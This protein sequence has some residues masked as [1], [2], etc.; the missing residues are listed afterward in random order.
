MLVVQN[1]HHFLDSVEI[2]Q[3]IQNGLSTWKAQGSCL[4]IVGPPIVF[5]PELAKY[6]TTLEFQLPGLSD[7]LHIQEEL[8]ESVGV[9]DERT[10]DIPVVFRTALS[11]TVDETKG[12]KLGAI[13]YHL[14]PKLPEK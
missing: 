11:E 10:R 5:P 1:F 3:E 13:G 2:I 7:L 8:G 9:A 4:V 14:P 12:L 6:F